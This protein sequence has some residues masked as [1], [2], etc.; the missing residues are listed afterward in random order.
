LESATEDFEIVN[1]LYELGGAS[2]VELTDAQA[3]YVSAASSYYS[4]L[5]DYKIAVITWEKALGITQKDI[6]R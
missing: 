2:S 1:R 6:K 4:T 5:Y 3:L